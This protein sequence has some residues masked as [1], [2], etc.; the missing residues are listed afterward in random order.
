M[1]GYVITQPNDTLFGKIEL[2]GDKAMS[3]KC[4]FKQQDGTLKTYLPE[5]I[6]GYRISKYKYFI[7]KDLDGKKAFFEF[8]IKGK[9]NVYY[10]L[11]NNNARYFIEKE[12]DVLRELPYDEIEKN[13]DGKNYLYKTTKHIG[14]LTYYLEN[15]PQ[16]RKEINAIKKPNHSNLIKIAE[17]YHN[18]VCDDEKCIVYE[19]KNKMRL[20]SEFFVGA[21]TERNSVDDKLETRIQCG[22][23]A[24]IWLPRNGNDIYFKGGLLFSSSSNMDNNKILARIPILIEKRFNRNGRIRPK[25]ATGIRIFYY[26]GAVSLVIPLQAGLNVK[27]NEKIYWTVDILLDGQFS[28]TNTGIGF[29]F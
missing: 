13:E 1:D 10:V 2:L 17:N 26:D 4:V 16:L 5:D 29:S 23:L 22:A 21:V 18:I 6:V 27:L 25:I 15:T 12:G 11:T 14:E 19:Q 8:L 24:T 28:S 3:E 9:L 20:G 7:T